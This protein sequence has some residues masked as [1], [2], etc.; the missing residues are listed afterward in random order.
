MLLG[1][2]TCGHI[3][4]ES[5]LARHSTRS[6]VC[7]PSPGRGGGGLGA[8]AHSP[9]MK[10]IYLRAFEGSCDALSVP[11]MSMGQPLLLSGVLWLVL[12]PC[13]CLFAWEHASA[14]C[15][16][17]LGV[18]AEWL[19]V[20]G[21]DEEW[22]LSV[23]DDLLQV[24][25][26]SCRW[27]LFAAM[28]LLGRGPCCKWC[29]LSQ[30]AQPPAQHGDVLLYGLCLRVGPAMRKKYLVQHCTIHTTNLQARLLTARWPVVDSGSF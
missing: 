1:L 23:A 24:V 3:H 14:A 11:D 20:A 9:S 4:R 21:C 27:L 17:P 22:L 10:G 28:W 6:A 12:W 2:G 26:V 8:E 15:W 13:A 7:F 30:S 16:W 18:A 29:I 25:S 5:G 19:E